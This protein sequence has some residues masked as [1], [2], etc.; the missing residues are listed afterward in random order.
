MP[1]TKRLKVCK[2]CHG[3][4]L[5]SWG[6]FPCPHCDGKGYDDDKPKE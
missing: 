3:S 2:F 5:A 1:E 6:S 4:G